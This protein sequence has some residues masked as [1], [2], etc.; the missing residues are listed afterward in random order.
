MRNAFHP[1]ITPIATT[2]NEMFLGVILM[3]ILQVE[4]VLGH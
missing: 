2:I 4:E 3:L 1:I